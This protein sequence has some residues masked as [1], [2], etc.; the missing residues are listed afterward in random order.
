MEHPL[1][2]PRCFSARSMDL[3]HWEEAF[4]RIEVMMHWSVWE[5][6]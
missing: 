4:A 5:E 3:G 2:F 6:K 1:G